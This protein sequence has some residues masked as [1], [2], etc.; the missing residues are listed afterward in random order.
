M[1]NKNPKIDLFIKDGCGRCPLGGT[2]ECKVH[3]WTNEVKELRKIA[4]QC[5]LSEELKWG[6]PCYTI[7]GK[8][9]LIIGVLKNCCTLSF[10]KGALLKDS[11]NILEKPGENSQA[12]KLFRFT[13]LQQIKKLDETLKD[14]IHEAIEVELSGAK[15]EFKAMSERDL[16][17]ELHMKFDQLPALRS[18]FESLTPGRQRGYLLYF[19]GAK[20]SKTRESRIEKCIPMILE[21]RGLHD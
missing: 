16:P 15:V 5:G 14:Y 9:V 17:V 19:Q 2:P 12:A 20:Q 13:S 3:L 8:N 6:C 18:A 11:A 7:D 4:L 21:G 10:F 1:S